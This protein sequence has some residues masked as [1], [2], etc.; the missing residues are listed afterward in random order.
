MWGCYMLC[1][2]TPVPVPLTS[3]NRGLQRSFKGKDRVAGQGGG[4]G[5][6]NQSRGRTECWKQVC[7]RSAES[8]LEAEDTEETKLQ[9]LD[10]LQHRF[11]HAVV[12]GADL[13]ALQG[14]TCCSS[15]ERWE[16]MSRIYIR[17]NILALG[18]WETI[19]WK[20]IDLPWEIRCLPEEHWWIS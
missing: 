9:Y 16:K 3:R 6:K 17:V 8:E 11:N 20:M 2:Q 1:N 4:G 14:R 5:I 13:C 7:R 19:R 15:T 10:H 18:C 12:S